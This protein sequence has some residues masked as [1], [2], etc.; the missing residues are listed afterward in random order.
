[1]R[2]RASVKRLLGR[3][4]FTAHLDALLL[5]NAAVVVAFHRIQ[6]TDGSDSLTTDAGTFER[7]CRF[8][9]RHFRVVSLRNLVL[10]LEHGIRVD[11]H[12]AITFDDGYRDNFENALPVLEKLSLPATFFV[13]SDWIGTDVVPWW[14]RERGVRHPWMR[15]GEVRSLHRKG[16]EIGAHTRTHV[17]LGKVS[18]DLAREEILGARLDLE[19]QIGARVESFAYPYG[20]RN[21]LTDA[22]RELV[23]AAGFRCC[24]SGFGGINL[25]GADPFSLRRVPVSSTW[26]ASPHQFGFDVALREE[27]QF[28]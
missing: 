28:R 4:L 22:N 12:L 11:H 9:A 25:T 17:D 1:M 16:F 20:G 2:V 6:E 27:R 23:K 7:Y 14:D 3:S 21:H 24:C 18:P 19:R 15:W 26:Y 10:K 5:R 13:V 8:F